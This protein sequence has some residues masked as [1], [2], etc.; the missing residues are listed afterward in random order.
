MDLLET[1]EGNRSQAHFTYHWDAGYDVYESHGYNV[2]TSQ[3]H[4]YAVDWSPGRLTYYID[5]KEMFSTTS[6]VPQESMALGFMGW[7]AKDGQN[8]Y[9]G[10][11]DGSTPGQ[12]NLHVDWAKISVADGGSQG[13]GSP[14]PAAVQAEPVPAAVVQEPAPAPAPVEAPQ[15]VD[16]EALAAQVLANYEATGSWYM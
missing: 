11:P 8:W 16:W 6:N 1:P 13:G 14:Q 3:W 10:G 4:T 15:A 5:G 2:D 9:N 7:V 12:V